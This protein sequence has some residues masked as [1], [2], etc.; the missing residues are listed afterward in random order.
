MAETGADPLA[1]HAG[2][3]ESLDLLW[4]LCLAGIGVGAV[5]E[6]EFVHLAYHLLNAVVGLWLALWEECH[7]AYLGAD[8]EHG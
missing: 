6:A 3:V 1:V 8:E 2:D 4:A 5:A 7:V